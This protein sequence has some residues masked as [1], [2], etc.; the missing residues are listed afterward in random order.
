MVDGFTGD[1]QFFLAY[2]QS[3]CDYRR[4]ANL[5][6][7]VITDGHAPEQYRVF[8]VRNVDPWYTAFSIKETDKL[9]LEPKDRV[10]IW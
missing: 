2:A 9:Y 10:R 1:Q 7:L 5:R 3:W 4:P 6:Q 8:T